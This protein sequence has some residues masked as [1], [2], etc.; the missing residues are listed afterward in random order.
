MFDQ[1]LFSSIDIE[2]AGMIR[3]RSGEASSDLVATTTAL[4]SA[5]RR[6]GNTCIRLDD[7]VGLAVN[8]PLH[9]NQTTTL[10]NRAAWVTALEAS[11]LVSTGTTPAPLVL[12]AHGRCFFYRDWQSEGV[13]VRAVEERAEASRDTLR[14]PTVEYLRSIMRDDR[15][16][17]VDRQALAVCAALHNRITF[18]CGG[19]GTG[20][21]TTI[22][23]MIDAFL[24]EDADTKI[25]LAAPT[26]KA[27]ARISE[28]LTATRARAHH[29]DENVPSFEAEA[30]TLHR[31]LGYRGD[32]EELAYGL[33]KKLDVDVLIIDEASMIDVSMMAA[34]LAALSDDTTLVMLGDKDQLASVDAGY[35]FGDLCDGLG[36]G[37]LFSAEFAEWCETVRVIGLDANAKSGSPANLVVELDKSYRFESKPQ[38][39]RLARAVLTADSRA[40]I[41]A[42]ETLAKPH[43]TNVG[44]LIER[45]AAWLD[46]L[47]ESQSPA[48]AL[49]HLEAFRWLAPLK[50]GRFGVQDI[51]LRVE[52]FL[53]SSGHIPQPT[54]WYRG[55]PIMM[56][57]NDTRARLFNGDVGVIWPDEDGT[58]AAWFV[59]PG[60]NPRRFQL[61]QLGSHETAWAMTVHKSQGSEFDEVEVILPTKENSNVQVQTRDLLY[62]AVTRARSRVSI[63]G[64][65][66][67][68]LQ[69]VS[70]RISRQTGLAERFDKAERN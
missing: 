11:P 37:R 25:A 55:R 23:K 57:S 24:L 39:G 70:R 16:G 27:A 41:E 19:P 36:A 52:Q 45:R 40:L 35:V 67:Q 62:T 5:A 10:P 66:D 8:D 50:Q 14:Q 30:K 64:D 42:S 58:L 60:G 13:I 56:R 44:T 32:S 43:P 22:S 18:V 46:A 63:V 49:T 38:I 33:E 51:N 26:G 3:R 2:L 48:E 47:L 4:V 34:L 69:A 29:R 1:T 6:M 12:D 15:A 54:T 68:L 17:Q 53:V 28:A 61:W 65:T 59:N 7:W 31:L 9:P 20:K 21:T